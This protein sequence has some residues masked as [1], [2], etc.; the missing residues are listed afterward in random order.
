MARDAQA[1]VEDV[2]EL[3]STP[4]HITP[5][6]LR[7][8]ASTSVNTVGDRSK[9]AE[10]TLDVVHRIQGGQENRFPVAIPAYESFTSDGSADNTETFNL[11]HS[12][13]DTPVTEDAIVYLDGEYYGE[14]DAI[15]Y[16]ADSIDVTDPN[17]GSTVHVWYISD[18]AATLEI[19]KETPSA[20]TSSKQELYSAPLNLVHQTNQAEQNEYFTFSDDPFE[21]YIA[22]DMTLNVYVK[23]PYEVRF[24]AEGGAATPDNMLLNIPV[25]KGK[26][27]VEGFANFIAN[28]MG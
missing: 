11:S 18:E 5:R 26:G 4:G 6:D 16:G 3:S 28:R 9:V 19:G 14:P 8:E 20:K 13:I 1:I 12:V 7:R 25:E 23:A 27:T 24:E 2:R 21:P 17:T 10:W 15:D 22:D